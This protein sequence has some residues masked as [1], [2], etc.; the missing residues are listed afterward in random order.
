MYFLHG[1]HSSFCKAPLTIWM[2]TNVSVTDSFPGASVFLVHISAAFVLV[3]LLVSKGLVFL[4]VLSA[5]RSESRAALPRTAPSRTSGHCF[6]LAFGHKESP[7]GLLPRGSSFH[8]VLLIILYH[9]RHIGFLLQ[10][11]AKCCKTGKLYGNRLLGECDMLQCHIMPAEHG[12]S[13]RMQFIPDLLPG[14]VM[15]IAVTENHLFIRI[16][17]RSND[18]PHLGFQV[19]KP[20]DL[21]VYFVLQL[22][23]LFKPSDK[24]A[25][26]GRLGL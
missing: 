21:S 23:D 8:S 1:S 16:G 15:D 11:V 20:V 10:S 5:L 13:V 18:I 14:H 2:L 3:V 26:V 22:P 4:A 9:S 12:R 24:G 19:N 17:N 25:S 6:H 7:T